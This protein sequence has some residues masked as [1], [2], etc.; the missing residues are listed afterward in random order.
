MEI[1]FHREKGNG[2]WQARRRASM[3]LDKDQKVDQIH[4]QELILPYNTS[5]EKNGTP[6][7]W[8]PQVLFRNEFFRDNHVKSHE[9]P[10]STI[11]ETQTIASTEVTTSFHELRWNPTYVASM[12][13]K[14]CVGARW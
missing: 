12:E 3:E 11:M 2:S 1:G 4:F 14:I 5:M 9:V 7:D 8:K 6:T 13:A 10:Y